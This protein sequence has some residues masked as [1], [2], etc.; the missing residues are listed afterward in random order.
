MKKL[1]KRVVC[2]IV[3]A[4]TLA[5]SGCSQLTNLFGSLSGGNEDELFE[6]KYTQVSLA[7]VKSF[8]DTAGECS[9]EALLDNNEGLKVTMSMDD[10]D[11]LYVSFEYYFKR[12]GVG[13]AATYCMKGEIEVDTKTIGSDMAEEEGHGEGSYYA[14]NG[15]IYMRIYQKYNGE[16]REEKYKA[17]ITEQELRQQMIGAIDEDYFAP[18]D[19]LI[20]DASSEDELISDA[21]S[22]EVTIT[23]YMDASTSDYTKIKFVYT[24][25]EEGLQGSSNIIWV[26]DG[27]KNL[28]AYSDSWDS[29]I[30]YS[31]S[32]DSSDDR[33]SGEMS[34]V[35]W[36]GTITPPSDLNT[37]SLRS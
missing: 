15:F 16:N 10:Y 27:Q 5:L 18:L 9:V 35:P 25:E 30:A 4:A 32:W 24:T 21:S 1:A 36:S 11:E 23:W 31:D 17:A 14:E 6:G 26:Y 34:I 33:E 20:S 22:E 19:E 37:Y 12:N 7:E 28:I 13:D 29:S 3:A 2:G 8:V